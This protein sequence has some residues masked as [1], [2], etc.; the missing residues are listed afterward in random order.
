MPNPRT[1]SPPMPC[2]ARSRSTSNRPT[3]SRPIT[4]SRPGPPSPDPP[5]MTD[6]S[7]AD[8]LPGDVRADPFGTAAIRDRVLDSWSAAP[9]RF[10]EDANAED[11]LVHGAYRD[12]VV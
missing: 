7:V 3:R 1:P 2:P 4:P 11:E 5:A 12:R 8:L 6:G 10:R 9:V